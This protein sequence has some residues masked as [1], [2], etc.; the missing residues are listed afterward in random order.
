MRS[1]LKILFQTNLT[2]YLPHIAIW[3]QVEKAQTDRTRLPPKPSD[4]FVEQLQEDTLDFFVQVQSP[5]CILSSSATSFNKPYHWSTAK[6]CCREEDMGPGHLVFLGC[7]SSGGLFYRSFWLAT[8]QEK[9]TL[10]PKAI[11]NRK[12]RLC[13][14][15]RSG[16]RHHMRKSADRKA[17]IS[18][19]TA[20]NA[21]LI[22]AFRSA[23]FLR[24]CLS[25]E[26]NLAHNLF[27]LFP[28]VFGINLIHFFNEKRDGSIVCFGDS[29]PCHAIWQKQ[30][31]A[32]NDVYCFEERNV[33]GNGK[34][35]LSAIQEGRKRCTFLA[36]KSAKL[37]T[38]FSATKVTSLPSHSLSHVS[39]SHR[40]HFTHNIG[41]ASVLPK[42]KQWNEDKFIILRHRA[43]SGVQV[44][45]PKPAPVERHLHDRKQNRTRHISCPIP[46]F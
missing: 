42:M 22:C 45:G 24:W 43:M 18:P 14:R 1:N 17:Q 33:F 31:F 6:H 35:E 30:N 25:P 46:N 3:N 8:Q 36:R 12:K 21:V 28:I 23:D 5:C 16:D 29:I 27:F 4:N 19:V 41:S 7:S 39:L 9:K 15:L 40:A 32:A 10:I 37:I 44:R 2:S 13:V 20:T 34:C 26:R 11:G 38:N